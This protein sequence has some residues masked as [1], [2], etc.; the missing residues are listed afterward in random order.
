MVD[1]TKFGYEYGKNMMVIKAIYVLNISSA[2][3]RDFLVETLYSMG[4]R[5]SYVDPDLWL[6][7]SVKLDSFDY[8]EYILC[9]I[10]DVLFISPN[11]QKLM[12]RIQE[13]FNLKDD[14]IKPPDVDVGATLDKIKLESGK[15][16]LDHVARTICKSGSQRCGRGTRHEHKYIA[17]KMCHTAL[18]QLCTLAGGFLC[19]DGGRCAIIPGTYCPAK[20]GHRDRT[21]GYPVGDVTV[22]KLP[23]DSLGLAP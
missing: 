16:L 23:R 7:P 3:F 12:K 5:S 2:A 17:I 19:Y 4:C 8:Y 18:G 21:T 22:I 9:Y 6:R 11:L 13:D 14:T 10:N 15:V 20:V 1:G